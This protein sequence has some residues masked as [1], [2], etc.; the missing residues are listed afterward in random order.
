MTELEV[1]AKLGQVIRLQEDAIDE[2]YSVAAQYATINELE[3]TDAT[4]KIA[5][6]SAIKKQVGIDIDGNG[7]GDAG[8]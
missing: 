4:R 7:M 8:R 2:L 5:A 6:A 1:V 3:D